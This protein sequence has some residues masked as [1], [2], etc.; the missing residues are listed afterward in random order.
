MRFYNDFY[1][2]DKVE[3]TVFKA[4]INVL[5]DGALLDTRE[6]IIIV[7]GSDSRDTDGN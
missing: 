5:G 3:A 1:E 6:V 2:P 7:P 4:K